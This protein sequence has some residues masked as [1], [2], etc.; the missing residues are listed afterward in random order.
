MFDMIISLIIA[1]IVLFIGFYL[2]KITKEELK[3]FHDNFVNALIITNSVTL[4]ILLFFLKA[5]LIFIYPII[6]V[7]AMLFYKLDI[8]MKL[9]LSKIIYL[10][11]AIMITIFFDNFLLAATIIQGFLISSLY[12]EL[13]NKIK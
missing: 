4:F 10:I 12:Y 9:I 2:A 3:D 11:S 7:F 13:T 8:K 1:V 5:E 6:F